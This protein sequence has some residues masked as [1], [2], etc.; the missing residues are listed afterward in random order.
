MQ[1]I[2][3]ESVSEELLRL[4]RQALIAHFTKKPMPSPQLEDPLFQEQRGVFVTLMNAG[5]LRGC[6][7]TFQPEQT[8]PETICEYTV[9]SATDR[10][11]RQNPITLKEVPQL[12]I[13]I[14]ILSPLR[15]IQQIEEIQIGIHGIQVSQGNVS[16]C[17]LPE[18]ATEQGW[19]RYEF[20][21]YCLKHKAHLPAMSW[22]NS[23]TAIE[24]FTTIKIQEKK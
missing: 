16:G 5:T 14:S 6:I 24:V 10:R 15:P 19:D 13:S 20:V 9:A 7:G 11:F 3:S 17:F 2:I 8:L 18:V 21:E 1:E 4:A 12:Q 22:Q 23:K